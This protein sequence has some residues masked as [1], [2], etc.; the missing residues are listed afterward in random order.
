MRNIKKLILILF[1]LC[2]TFAVCNVS[3]CNNDD[4]SLF[5]SISYAISETMEVDALD[6]SMF[7]SLSD[8]KETASINS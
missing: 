4:T 5:T 1:L 6:M 8:G 7:I 3:A 2:I